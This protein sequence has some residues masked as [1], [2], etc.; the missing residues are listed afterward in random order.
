MG[1]RTPGDDVPVGGRVAAIEVV[2]PAG[3]PVLL[4]I[5]TRMPTNPST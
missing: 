4:R 5:T 2:T 1:Y 3:V